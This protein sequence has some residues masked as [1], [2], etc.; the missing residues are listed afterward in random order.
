[1]P[2]TTLSIEDAINIANVSHDA[3]QEPSYEPGHVDVPQLANAARQL[4]RE[5]YKLHGELDRER[6]RAYQLA[7]PETPRVEGHPLD[8]GHD[9]G[10][11][12]HFLAGRPVHPGQPL[13]LLTHLGWHPVRYESNM[14]KGPALLYFSLPGSC[15]ESVIAAPAGDHIRLAWPEDL[16][17][18]TTS[19]FHRS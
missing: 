13:Y 16:N 5:I 11:S 15:D 18:P 2:C 4:A 12:R 8:E 9:E 14:P 6:A 10:G 3:V 7:R 19:L 1:M 17:R